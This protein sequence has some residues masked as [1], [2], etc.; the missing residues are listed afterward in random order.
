MVKESHPEIDESF[1]KK[2]LSA[3]TSAE[4]LQAL[5]HKVNLPPLTIIVEKELLH[6]DDIGNKKFII[7]THQ[8]GTKGFDGHWITIFPDSS[9]DNTFFFFDPY[10]QK[11]KNKYFDI[12]YYFPEEYRIID[13]NPNM[14]FQSDETS[15]CGWYCIAV[16]YCWYVLSNKKLWHVIKLKPIDKTDLF[17]K[18]KE[19]KRKHNDILVA[20][21]IH[22]ISNNDKNEVINHFKI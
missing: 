21:F 10:G 1:I 2:N 11:F 17:D 5:A 12:Y 16:L 3:P 20:H 14:D 8:Y 4:Q 9:V 6:M 22:I 13:F 18:D 7:L 15:I 19:V